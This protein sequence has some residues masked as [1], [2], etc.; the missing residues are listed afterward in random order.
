MWCTCVYLCWGLRLNCTWVRNG[1][2]TL[3]TFLQLKR[4]VTNQRE[5]IRFSSCQNF[6]SCQFVSQPIH[7]V[8]KLY[9]IIAKFNSDKCHFFNL[10]IH[11]S[12]A[13]KN[14]VK[15]VLLNGISWNLF[16]TTPEN[17][18][19]FTIS[20]NL[21]SVKKIFFT[22]I[23]NVCDL[24]FE[25]L[26]LSCVASNILQNDVSCVKISFDICQNFDS[27]QNLQQ[28]NW[29]GFEAFNVTSE[30]DRIWIISYELTYVKKL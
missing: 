1:H 21:T 30:N 25:I 20:Y 27:Y 4:F 11:N 28:P 22:K 8:L 12:T 13:Y 23:S 2:V 5:D 18:R 15:N 3:L 19:I 14:I 24:N 10:R 17:D 9:R 6:D 7:C 16:W 26:S 29:N